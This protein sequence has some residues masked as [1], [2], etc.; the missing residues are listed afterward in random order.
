MTMWR[1]ES[2]SLRCRVGGRDAIEA[3]LAAVRKKSPRSLGA[4]FVATPING[5]GKG[6]IQ[7][8]ACERIL[9]K[10]RLWKDEPG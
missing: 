8:G 6:V 1:I 10:A 4:I 7:Y 2:G 5:P 3:F 9:R